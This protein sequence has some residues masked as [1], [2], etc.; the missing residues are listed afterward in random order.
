[1]ETYRSARYF[2]ISIR[3]WR[4]T[5]GNIVEIAASRLCPRRLGLAR[6]ATTCRQV[7]HGRATPTG[8]WSLAYSL[9]SHSYIM[10]I[11]VK[12]VN[13]NTKV[14]CNSN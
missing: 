2:Y 8:G 11:K 14:L 10:L 3:L 12:H 4:P 13:K 5:C 6:V 7:D 1:M 9:M